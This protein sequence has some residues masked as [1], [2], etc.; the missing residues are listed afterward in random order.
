MAAGSKGV[1]RNPT[2]SASHAPAATARPRA[3]ATNPSTCTASRTSVTWPRCSVCTTKGA[4][5]SIPSPT[6][7]GPRG[8][9]CR[10]RARAARASASTETP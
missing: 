1:R 9:I 10:A 7:H 3:H 4:Q 6:A 5:A 8:P 2:P